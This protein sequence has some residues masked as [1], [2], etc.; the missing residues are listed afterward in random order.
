MISDTGAAS[1]MDTALAAREAAETFGEVTQIVG[2]RLDAEEY[3]VPITDVQEIIRL[4]TVSITRIP[5]APRFVEGVVNLRGRMV[6]VVDLRGRFGLSAVEHARSTRV[7]VL[8]LADRTFGIVVDEVTEVVRV[9][10]NEIEMLP[11]LVAGPG[12]RFVTGVARVG[13]R[14]VVVLDLNRLFTDEEADAFDEIASGGNS[15]DGKAGK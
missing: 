6:P 13:D 3:G 11:D 10:S 5:N 4:R 2:F 14:M 1:A 7:V 15:E 12:S 9:P 8:R